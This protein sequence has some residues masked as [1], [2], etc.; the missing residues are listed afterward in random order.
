MAD[1]PGSSRAPGGRDGRRTASLIF[2]VAGIYGVVVL[3][4]QYLLELGIGPPLPGPLTRP[5]HFYGFI[6]VALAFQFV[7]LVIATDP[8][9]YRLL[10]LC[11]VLEKLSFGV[12][13][14][15]LYAA[16]RVGGDVL[17]FGLIDLLLGAVFLNAYRDM[18]DFAEGAG[19]ARRVEAA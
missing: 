13:V 6:G 19:A 11:G 14:I 16:G 15:L 17:A 8:V 9:R 18:R 1:V 3:L 5:E 7:F 4:P 10:M 2:R 12:P